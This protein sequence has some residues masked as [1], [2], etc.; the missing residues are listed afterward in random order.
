MKSVKI[1]GLGWV[2]RAMKQLF[3]DAIIDDPSLDLNPT[4]VCD[5]AFICVPTPPLNG[6]LDGSIVESVVARAKESLIVI[7]S[8]IMPGTTDYLS[9]KYHKRLIFS[10]EYIGESKF[11]NLLDPRTRD[12]LIFGGKDKDISELVGIYTNAYNAS[13]KIRTVTPYEAE[14]IKLTENRAIAFKVSQCQEL[15]DACEAAGINYYTVRDAVYSDDPRF[16]LWFTFIY[17]ENRGFGGKCLSKD[18][19]A[20]AAWVESL[21]VSAELTKSMLNYNDKLIEANK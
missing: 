19:P 12:F 16:N 21:G 2:G 14:V 10:P 18:V 11:H 7:R 20:W 6:G 5:V 4:E 8:T 1:Y 15:Y 17:P 3:P 9:D 13:I